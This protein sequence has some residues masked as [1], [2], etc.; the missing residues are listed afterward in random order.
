MPI[1]AA[2]TA[3]LAIDL[4]IALFDALARCLPGF[5]K[6]SPPISAALPLTL[7]LIGMLVMALPAKGTLAGHKGEA[8]LGGGRGGGL[9]TFAESAACPA[10]PCR[11][12]Q[13]G[14]PGR[15]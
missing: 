15:N 1:G 2:A 3:P 5:N 10:L 14:V 12:S 4:T 7:C 13:Q 9:Y 6:L 8:N 11:T